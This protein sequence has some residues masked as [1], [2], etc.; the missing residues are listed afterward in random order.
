M[1]ASGDFTVVVVFVVF[2]AFLVN[3]GVAGVVRHPLG[4]VIDILCRSGPMIIVQDRRQCDCWRSW[5]M[6]D[7]ISGAINPCGKDPPLR[8]LLVPNKRLILAAGATDIS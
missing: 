8:R 4:G 5:L 6:E 1:V 3:A 7:A 2:S